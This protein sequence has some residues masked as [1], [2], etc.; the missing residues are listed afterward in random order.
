M[1]WLNIN[2]AHREDAMKA[3][4]LLLILSLLITLGFTQ[5]KA[6]P[7]IKI[8][9]AVHNCRQFSEHL[10][11]P[12][13]F[14]VT[15][16]T[17]YNRGPVLYDIEAGKLIQLPLLKELPGVPEETAAK[18]GSDEYKKQ[19]LE[20]GLW[21][22][23]FYTRILTWAPEAGYAD[24]LYIKDATVRT[25]EGEPDCP[26]CGEKSKLVEKYQRYYCYGCKKYVDEKDYLKDVQTYFIGRYDIKKKKVT[27]MNEVDA[28]NMR[29]LI[30][31]PDS[32]YYY[33]SSQLFFYGDEVTK[34]DKVSVVRYS[35]EKG[36]IDWKHTFKVVKRV[37]S[38]D[39]PSHSLSAEISPD[40][41]KLIFIEYDE[42]M[43]K[44]PGPRAY[45]LDVES[46]EV[47][48]VP[49]PPTAYG[50]AFDRQSRWLFLGSN[51]K[52]TVH[53]Y[54]LATGK[55]ELKIQAAGT[56]FH[57][58]I[59]PQSKYLFVFN[60]TKVEVR[61]Y[62]DLKL[63]KTI[64]LSAIFKGVNQLLVSEQMITTEDGKYSV[65]GILKTDS[66]WASSDLED[67]FYLLETL[68]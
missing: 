58:V 15:S 24:I 48:T 1:S 64:P 32:R 49:V 10:V 45:F 40:G 65:I 51:Q 12:T 42:G 7:G 13:G 23:G 20:G 60:K 43:L 25:V 50:R 46:K 26:K 22:W 19:K 41:K 27:E 21:K 59:S 57:F 37:K 53:R 62:P 11:H 55:E 66:Q 47:V 8:A 36:K 33:F 2:K 17:N 34:I 39:L 28:P 31:S 30:K 35:V 14:V 67:G 61:A 29:Y 56:I 18:P 3:V 5:D 38:E 68:E 44:E 6:G 54:D 63:I 16:A 4:T 52:G 9:R